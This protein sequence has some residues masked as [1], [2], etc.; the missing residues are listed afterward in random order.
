MQSFCYVGA[1]WRQ[2][3]ATLKIIG[4]VFE[5]KEQGIIKKI[6]QLKGRCYDNLFQPMAVVWKQQGTD[7]RKLKD[8]VSKA[9]S[10]TLHK[11][12]PPHPCF[13][14]HLRL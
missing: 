6:L 8:I 7:P 13:S 2:I 4:K 12:F 1:L 9:T 10:L 3:R 14:P 5:N 11:I